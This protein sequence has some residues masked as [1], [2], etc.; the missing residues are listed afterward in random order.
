MAKV[1]TEEELNSFSR[2]TLMALIL[3]MKDQ[4]SLHMA[5]P[6]GRVCGAKRPKCEAE[7]SHQF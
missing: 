2:E 6:N 7:R 5:Y 3:S 1:Y 4:I